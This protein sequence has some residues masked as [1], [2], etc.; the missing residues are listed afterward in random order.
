MVLNKM[1]ILNM[2]VKVIVRAT[3]FISKFLASHVE[4][5]FFVS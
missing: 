3:M 1:V 4:L 2:T 5:G